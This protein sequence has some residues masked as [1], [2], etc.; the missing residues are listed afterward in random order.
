M[1]D[2]AVILPIGVVIIGG[3]IS[4]NKEITKRPTFKEVDETYKK[5][6]VCDEIHK[7]I[8]E[9]LEPIPK[10]QKILTKIAIKMHIDELN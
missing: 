6:E 9:K 8:N 4:I 7:S 1:V 10:M 2:L 5:K 3:L